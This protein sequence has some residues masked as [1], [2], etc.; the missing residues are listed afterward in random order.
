MTRAL[1][2][3]YS[4]ALYHVTSRG[5]RR[6]DI[7]D[8]DVDRSMFL[9]LLNDV[10][11]SYNWDCHGYCLMSN[12]YHLLIETPEPN[13]S[14]GMRQLN[15]VYSQKYN[16]RHNKVG[17]VFQG[18]YVSIL[19]EKESY[20]LELTRYIV[21]NPVRAGMVVQASDWPWS[22]YRA[23]IGKVVAPDWLNGD[24]ILSCFG[25]NKRKSIKRYIL[26][27][28]EGVAKESPLANVKNQIFL[29][30]EKFVENGLKLIE[31]HKDLSEVPRIQ[32][33]NPRLSLETYAEISCSRNEAI[34]SAYKS[35]GYTL[36]EV[37]EFFGL[38]Y[39][40]V[41]RIVRDS[42]FKT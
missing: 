42:K 28:L 10:C 9:A 11:E 41:S 5:D 35:G 27:V 3:E 29:G 39:S 34:I 32:K 6:E 19:V 26:F 8:D 25:S 20:L 2:L 16:Y 1:R 4:G 21:L 38:G 40:M 14:A 18:R 15:G 31:V 37:G 23:V 30:S 12:H 36:K 7:Y 17:H 22:S 13:L 24:W 33:R